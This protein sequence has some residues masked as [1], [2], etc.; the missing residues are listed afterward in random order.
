VE[1][2]PGAPD[3]AFEPI[4]RA[5]VPAMLALARACTEP[6]IA[7]YAVDPPAAERRARLEGW[8]AGLPWIGA[9]FAQPERWYW[10][11][12]AGRR[13][14]FVQ[15]GRNGA[16]LHLQL[17]V[18][19]PEMRGTG[20]SDV[21]LRFVEEQAR[22]EGCASVD[23]YV[24]RRNYRAQHLYLRHGFSLAPERR[25]VFEVKRAARPALRALASLPWHAL[26]EAL[27][28]VG[29]RGLGASLGMRAHGTAVLSLGDEA[30]ADAVEGALRA[31]F[32]NTLA[33]EARLVLTTAVP[34]PN[35]RL[36]AILHRM[37]RVLS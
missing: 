21:V 10:I 13:A 37:E 18:I 2:P 33:R 23:L 25:F 11:V 17:V 7:A 4:R 32:R 29:T 14:G 27:G 16:T 24:D 6:R 8:L 12:S 30:G 9:R 31:A 3:L 26:A 5:D 20:A 19:A 36:I 28:G 35:G 22:R 15:L 34:V 1:K